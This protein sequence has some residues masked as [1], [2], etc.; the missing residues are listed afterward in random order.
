MC[1]FAAENNYNDMIGRTIATDIEKD[2]QSGKIIVITGARQVGKTTL[3]EDFA[4]RF[5]KVLKLNC[6]NYDDRLDLENRRSTELRNLIGNSDFV[7]IDEAQR[8]NNIGLTL[9]ILADLKLNIPILVTGSSSFELNNA[10]NEAATGRFFD[11]RMYPFS[12]SEL[13]NHT[14]QR[15]EGRLLEQRILYGSYPDVVNHPEDARRIVTNLANNYLYRDLLEYKGMKKPE[16]LQKLVRALALQIGSEVSYNELAKTLGADKETIEN[17]IDLLEKCF[18][19]FRLSSF[20]RNMR[21]EIKKG[22]KIYFYDNGIRN[23]LIT[24]FAALELRNDKGALWENYLVSERIKK[25]RN[26]GDYSQCYFWRTNTQ[27]EI[28]LIEECDGKMRAYEFKWKDEKAKMPATFAETY[29]DATFQV[30]NTTNY[31]D[32][33]K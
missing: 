3:L 14:S 23:A 17:Y 5:S 26:T 2:F 13:A 1:N 10:I 24:N 7:M 15:D 8:V 27:Q 11:Y 12:F 31:Q 29:P 18:V 30:I 28:D 21:T 6:D 4:S 22:K 9:K 25:L 19:V 33:L 20:S 32:W 16:L